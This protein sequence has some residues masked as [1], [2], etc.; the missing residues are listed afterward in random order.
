MK[1]NNKTRTSF[2]F[3]LI[4]LIVA[5]AISSILAIGIVKMYSASKNSFY[6]QNDSS[7][8]QESGRFVFDMLIS[9]LRRSG[10]YGYNPGVETVS[11]SETQIV[12]TNTCPRNDTW[13]LM[14]DRRIIG[15]NDPVTPYDCIAADYLE[16]DVLSLRY[17]DGHNETAFDEDRYYLRSS[18]K[19]ARVFRG[20]KSN[21]AINIINDGTPEATGQLRAFVYYVGD[22]G[23][24][25]R[26]NDAKG[27]PIPIPTLYRESLNK[28][29]LPER[30]EVAS[31]IENIQFKYGIDSNN[32]KSVNQYFDSQFISNDLNVTPNWNQV[33]SVRFWILA[34][35]NCPAAKI[36]DIQKT[37]TMGDLPP[38]IPSDNIK[39]QLFTSTVAL[40]N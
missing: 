17:V 24:F 4:E 11:G 7:K 3:S 35:A 31:G 26:F 9:D 6:V 12:N 2:G 18:F 38:F 15:M 22:S 21:D 30:Q 25:C 28:K 19:T 29:G 16:G 33:V 40:R 20:A 10:Y 37:F 14:L 5:L 8:L 1:F 34:R 39:R 36:M 23:R 32:D 27:N 13:G